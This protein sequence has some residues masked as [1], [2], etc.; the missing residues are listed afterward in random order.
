MPQQGNAYDC[1]L[2]ACVNMELMSRG[3]PVRYEV[4][5]EFSDDNRKR[6]AVELMFGQLLTL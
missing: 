5:E 4:D 1:G 6:I 2:F 3:L